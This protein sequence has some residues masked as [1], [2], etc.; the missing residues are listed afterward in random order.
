MNTVIVNKAALAEIVTR[1]REMHR[2]VFL[3][4]IEGFRTTLQAN[5]EARLEALTQGKIPDLRINLVQPEDHTRDYDRILHMIEMHIPEDIEITQGDFARYVEDS[6]DWKQQFVTASNTYTNAD[7]DGT[8]SDY[9][10][11]FARPR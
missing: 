11:K 2:D 8:Q 4:A 1:N 5:L 3:Q 6:W 7:W 10:G 9:V